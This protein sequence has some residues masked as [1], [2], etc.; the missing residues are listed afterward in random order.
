MKK[1]E[2]LPQRSEE[3][4]ERIAAVHHTVKRTLPQIKHLIDHGIS[5]NWKARDKF[6]HFYLF[7]ECK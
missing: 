5:H 6:N 3:L 7:P 4:P 1:S 2:N